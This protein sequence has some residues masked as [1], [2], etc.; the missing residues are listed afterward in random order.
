MSA[1]ERVSQLDG[2]GRP[3][4]TFPAVGG[5]AAQR[6]VPGPDDALH[7]AGRATGH[8]PARGGAARARVPALRRRAFAL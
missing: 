7:G 6:A 8:S 5:D 1:E 4:H 3:A 2:P